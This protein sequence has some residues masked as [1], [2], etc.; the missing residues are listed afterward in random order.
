G[1][2]VAAARAMIRPRSAGR[3]FRRPGGR[4]HRRLM[5]LSPSRLGAR[6]L[7][8]RRAARAP[9]ALYRRGL[10]WLLGSRMLMLEH[11]GRR[12]GEARYAVLEVIGRPAPGRILIASGFGHGSQWYRNLE[13]EPRC[14]WATAGSGRPP[15]RRRSRPPAS[16]TGPWRGTPG[17]T[18]RH[19]A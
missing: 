4:W 9:V 16:P 17:R 15:P 3:A 5:A 7:R 10:G 18:P 6:V 1:P 14:T 12:S 13:A 11:V 8:N 19:G 2:H